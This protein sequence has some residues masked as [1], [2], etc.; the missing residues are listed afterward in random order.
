MSSYIHRFLYLC[1]NISLIIIF[2]LNFS[3]SC[4]KG[5]KNSNRFSFYQN[6]K[7]KKKIY[8]HLVENRLN[9]CVIRV[10]TTKLVRKR[11]S[12]GFFFYH[13]YVCIVNQSTSSMPICHFILVFCTVCHHYF[14]QTLHASEHS[15]SSGHVAEIIR[16]F[17]GKH[18]TA[19]ITR[20][21]V[22]SMVT[23]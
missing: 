10:L 18:K 3:V 7:K 6:C 23:S 9:L 11:F 4:S 1:V 21:S 19:V 16:Q 12:E 17:I 22:S 5:E 13:E 2:N 8:C 20:K 14:P 15:F